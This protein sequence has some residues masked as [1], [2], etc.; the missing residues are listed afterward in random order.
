MFRRDVL[1]DSG[2]DIEMVPLKGIIESLRAVKEPEE[3]EHI[4]KAVAIADAAY[5]YIENNVEAGMT[6]KQ[7]AWEMEKSLRENGSETVPFEIIV[8]SGPNAARPHARPSERVIQA[9]E[10]VLIDMGAKYQGY[11]SD[12]TRTVC[13]GMPD[14]TFL[15]LY[16]TVLDAQ[17]AAESIIKRGMTGHEA[18]SA[19][20]KII[21]AAGYGE[22]FGTA[23][24]AQS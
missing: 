9:G 20:R 16:E 21:E 22:L 13:V 3:I 19:A 1:A 24:A 14:D 6:E 8:A 10:P 7:V 12:L 2:A 23:R 15:K 17:E 4:Q 18:D 5:T 11:A